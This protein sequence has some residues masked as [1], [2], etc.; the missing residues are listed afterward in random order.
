MRFF[1]LVLYPRLFLLLPILLL[2]IHS[3]SWLFTQSCSFIQSVTYLLTLTHSPYS[4]IQTNR[5]THSLIHTLTH[6]LASLCLRLFCLAAM[7]QC[8]QARGR[9]NVLASL[10]WLSGVPWLPLLYCQ[11]VG[12]TPRCSSGVPLVSLRCPSHVPPVSL[13]CPSGVP[14][15]SLRYPSGDPPFPLLLRGMRRTMNIA[16]GSDIV[17]RAPLV[18]VTFEWQT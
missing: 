10:R 1:F 11:K 6:P 9:T 5:L 7:G 4:L 3:L 14:P 17:P 12:Y 15:V 2:Y 16:K 18:S 13:L 8:A